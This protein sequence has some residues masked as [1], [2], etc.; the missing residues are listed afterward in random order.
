MKLFSSPPSPYVRKVRIVAAM[1]GL[2]DRIDIVAA[3]TTPPHNAELIEQNPLGKI[4]VLVLDD[5]SRLFDSRVI[6]EYLDH[7]GE[8]RAPR[9]FPAPGGERWR[10]L[11][12]A[13][14]ADG[15]ADAGVLIVYEKR[16][17]EATHWNAGW[18]ARQ[19]A[20]VDAGL[21][22]FEAEP[23]TWSTAPDYGHVA[24]ACCL[25]HLDFRH[26]GR[27]RASRPKLVAWLERF[28]A[29][30]PAYAETMPHA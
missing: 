27:W 2:A 12:R 25:G 26:D 20:K 6:C 22:A 5:G 17:R 14:L 18:L 13:A 30:V 1:K 28:A 19:Q 7:E 23:P 3:D 29:D 15:I 10:M 4:P 16:F 11:T 8:A 21:D 24:L 9:L